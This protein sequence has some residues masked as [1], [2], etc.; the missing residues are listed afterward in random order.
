VKILAS[1]ILPLAN[2]RVTSQTSSTHYET[3]PNLSNMAKL[4][5]MGLEMKLEYRLKLNHFV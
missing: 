5:V 3:I 2:G 4:V 1:D